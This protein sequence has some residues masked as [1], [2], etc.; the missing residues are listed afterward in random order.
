M[1]NLKDPP[2]GSPPSYP[3]SL[4]PEVTHLQP[5]GTTGVMIPN[6][7]D[8]E[9]LSSTMRPRWSW[10]STVWSAITCVIFG[11][12][13]AFVGL[14]CSIFSYVDHKAGD[15]ERARFKRRCSWGWSMTGLVICVLLVIACI[16]IVV[17]FF[18]PFMGG[19]VRAAYGFR[20]G[21]SDAD[22]DDDDTIG[23]G[24]GQMADAFDAVGKSVQGALENQRETMDETVSVPG[25]TFGD[26]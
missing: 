3:G 19:L 7:S 26:W 4:Y 1:S 12:P 17:I 6:S 8:L 5:G 15:F 22:A 9:H 23:L 20:N 14:L 2:V 13:C 25:D 16:V 21:D 11:S 18:A 24:I 10:C